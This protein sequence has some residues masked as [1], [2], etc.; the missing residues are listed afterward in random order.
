MRTILSATLLCTLLAGCNGI[1]LGDNPPPEIA[2]QTGPLVVPPALRS[3][4]S[5]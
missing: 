3:G 2:K 5:R 4:P 1:D